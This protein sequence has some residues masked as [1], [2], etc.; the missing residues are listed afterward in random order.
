MKHTL[1]HLALFNYFIFLAL[2]CIIAPS[3]KKKKSDKAGKKMQEFVIELSQ[4]ARSKNPNFIVIPQNAPE[5]FFTDLNPDLEINVAFSDAVNGIGVEELFYNGD[6]AQDDYRLAMLRKIKLKNMVLV[7]D[8]LKSNGNYSDAQSKASNEGFLSF[9][10]ISENYDYKYVPSSVINENSDDIMTLEIAKNYLYLISSE[11]YTSK[12]SYLS[13]IQNSNFDMI[14]MDAFYEDALLTSSEV[15]ALKTKANG[16]K[17]LVIAYMSVG[18]AE[19]YRYYFKKNWG[20]R[21]PWWLKRKYEGYKDEFWVK[22]WCK[23]WK[24]IIYG[25]EN[26]YTQKIIDSQFDGAF[27][28]N[29]EAY[30]FLYYRD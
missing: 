22:F 11:N 29:V 1:T 20:L 28:D 23:E 3:C 26:S 27:L 7:A 12:E 18:S 15:E 21:R 4:Y 2:I 19:R 10:R 25:T 9:P 30:Y 24:D 6:F 13:A 17:R 16:G 5:L 8:Y 14:I